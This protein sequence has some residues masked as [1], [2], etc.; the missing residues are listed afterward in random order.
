M[1]TSYAIPDGEACDTECRDTLC[2]AV[3]VPKLLTAMLSNRDD[4]ACTR[5]K[6]VEGCN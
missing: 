2:R 1:S 3:C 4:E 6:Q 5:R